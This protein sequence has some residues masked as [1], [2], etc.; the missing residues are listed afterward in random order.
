M[1]LSH[2]GL[3]CYRAQDRQKLEGFSRRS[4]RARYW[5]I[6][7]PNFSCICFEADQNLFRKMLHNPEYVSYQFLPLF[8]PLPTVIPLEHAPTIDSVV[9]L[10]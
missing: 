6:H 8:L 3:N 4:T 7:S 1:L 2:G 10:I 5:S 9:C